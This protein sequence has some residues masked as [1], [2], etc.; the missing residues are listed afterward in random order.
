[1]NARIS[2][3]L[4]S[5]GRSVV[6]HCSN[7]WDSEPRDWLEAE[8]E[9]VWKP[10]IELEERDN[11]FLLEMAAAGVDPKDFDIQV[12]PEDILAGRQ[13]CFGVCW[14]CCR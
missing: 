3:W 9:L 6:F 8:R 10:A 2:A 12:T 13:V 7:R 5:Y 4:W 1:V 11:E 14:A